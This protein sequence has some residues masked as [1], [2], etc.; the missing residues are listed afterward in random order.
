MAAPDGQNVDVDAMMQRMRATE[1]QLA[2]FFSGMDAVLQ[3][4]TA[5]NLVTSNCDATAA[6]EIRNMLRAWYIREGELYSDEL[7]DEFEKFFLEAR[8]AAI[9]DG[10]PKEVGDALHQMYVQCCHNDDTLVKFFQGTLDAYRRSGV[11]E[12]CTFQKADDEA[13]S[14]DDAGAVAAADDD[15]DAGYAYDEEPAQPQRQNKSR[16]KNAYT[17]GADGWKTVNTSKKRR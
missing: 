7:E 14:D 17:T 15:D 11:A 5:L 2:V 13:D 16:G 10:S 1:E 9:E 12:S 3:Q 8:F 6:T 4:W